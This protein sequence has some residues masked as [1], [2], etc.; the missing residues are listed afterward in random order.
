MLIYLAATEAPIL[1]MQ[2]KRESQGRDPSPGNFVT[3][4]W[5]MISNILRDMQ[6]GRMVCVAQLPDRCDDPLGHIN[7]ATGHTGASI[8]AMPSRCLRCPVS[9]ASA[10]FAF[11]RGDVAAK[12]RRCDRMGEDFKLTLPPAS[13]DVVGKG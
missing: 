13:S 5:K 4:P 2:K 11:G 6:I 8:S 10:G 9:A 7:E 12:E 1:N 3:V